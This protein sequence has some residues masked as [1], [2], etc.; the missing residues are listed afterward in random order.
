M[1]E[2]LP[3]DGLEKKIRLGC[4]AVS[5]LVL[6][7]AAGFVL[8]GLRAG[9]LWAFGAFAS[10]TFAWLALRFGD[11]FWMGLMEAFGNLRW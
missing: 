9:W 4:G 6:G 11:R 10:G 7:V 2:E 5:G 8:F 3:P 1:Q